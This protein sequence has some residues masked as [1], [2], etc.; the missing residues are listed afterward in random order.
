MKNINER[1][2][3]LS[4]SAKVALAAGL[5]AVGG[6]AGASVA[7]LQRPSIEMAPTTV[8]PIANLAGASG[9]VAIRGRVAENFGNNFVLADNSGRTLIAADPNAAA[10][11]VG[12]IVTVQGR[13]DDGRLRPSFLTDQAGVVTPVGPARGPHDGPGR[14]GRGGPDRDG[15][16]RDG[17]RHGP[18]GRCGPDGGPPPPPPGAGAPPPPAANG[19]APPLPSAN[20]PASQPQPAAAPRAPSA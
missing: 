12:S 8:K 18:D 1:L 16:G 4:G 5:L 15:P 11:A 13:V 6:V 10:P 14:E 3:T 9:I 2:S 19:V 17:P 7:H 20:A